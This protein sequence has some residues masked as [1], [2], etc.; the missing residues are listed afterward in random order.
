MAR[1]HRRGYVSGTAA[2]L[3][4]TIFGLDFLVEAEEPPPPFGS[5]NLTVGAMTNLPPTKHLHA[6]SSMPS[7]N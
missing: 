5:N 1:T 3:S 2:R 4:V 7:I 6:P